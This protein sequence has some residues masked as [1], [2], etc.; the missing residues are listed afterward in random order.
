[1]HP[2]QGLDLWKRDPANQKSPPSQHTSHS[3]PTR[4]NPAHASIPWQLRLYGNAGKLNGL[5]KPS[6]ACTLSTATETIKRYSWHIISQGS[7][8]VKKSHLDTLSKYNSG[9][10]LRNDPVHQW[11]GNG[12]RVLLHREST[13]ANSP[14]VSTALP[15]IESTHMNSLIGSL[16]QIRWGRERLV[17]PFTDEETNLGR[18]TTIS[19]WW[20]HNS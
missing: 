9:W 5:D 12:G 13:A 3:R 10:S 6:S 18:F 1:M 14:D 16:Q 7:E 15:T 8:E 20:S 2:R 11:Q 4:R 19:Q 17:S